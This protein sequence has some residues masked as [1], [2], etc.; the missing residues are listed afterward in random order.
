MEMGCSV[1]DDRVS[2]IG[3]ISVVIFKYYLKLASSQEDSNLVMRL[4]NPTSSISVLKLE[5]MLSHL[6]YLKY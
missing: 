1:P 3:H 6:R 4:Y 5:I 2:Y